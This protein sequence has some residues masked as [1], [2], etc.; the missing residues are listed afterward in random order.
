VL[1]D[2]SAAGISVSIDDFGQGQTS[3]GYL[4]DLPIDELKIDRGFVS[5]AAENS[6]HVAIV[7]SIIDLGHNLSMRV[8]GEGV[9]DEAG[10]I[11]LQ[12]LGCDLAQGFHLARPMPFDS[13]V[14]LLQTSMATGAQL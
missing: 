2:L 4:S 9:E 7:R 3:L 6:Q 1:T 11:L 8:V 12:D 5:D 13:L 14:D 10:L